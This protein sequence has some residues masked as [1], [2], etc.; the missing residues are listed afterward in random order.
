M[1]TLKISK[2]FLSGL[3]LKTYKQVLVI[4]LFFYLFCSQ[5]FCRFVNFHQFL[6]WACSQENISQSYNLN[7][8]ITFTCFL[9]QMNSLFS[10]IL[11]VVLLTSY[12]LSPNLDLSLWADIV[13]QSII[14]LVANFSSMK[15][16]LTCFIGSS[17]S[18]YLCFL[19]SER[20]FIVN[21]R[22]YLWSNSFS[23]CFWFIHNILSLSAIVSVPFLLYVFCWYQPYLYNIFHRSCKIFYFFFHFIIF[24]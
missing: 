22:K 9:L 13:L 2:S 5:Y 1:I 4:L 24:S 11:I 7:H 18:S 21:S 14:T 17:T 16:L 6:L 19:W 3:I 10:L 20:Y 12:C 23:I 8:C 15:V